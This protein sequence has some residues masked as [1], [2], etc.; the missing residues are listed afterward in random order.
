MCWY[1]MT[2]PPWSGTKKFVPM[3]RSNIVRNCEPATNGVANTTSTDVTPVA[4]PRMGMR[5]MV[6]PGAR[7]VMMVARKLIAVAMD[8][9]PANCTPS[10][11]SVWPIVPW[12][13]RGG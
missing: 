12:L 3:M 8:D 5:Q 7:I 2:S 4:H 11:N 6:M 10:S 9:A 1:M 13:A